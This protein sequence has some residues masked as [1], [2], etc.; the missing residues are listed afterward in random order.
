MYE[1]HMQDSAGESDAPD[2]ERFTD[3]NVETPYVHKC[4]DAFFG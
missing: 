1:I 2:D 4:L 3:Y